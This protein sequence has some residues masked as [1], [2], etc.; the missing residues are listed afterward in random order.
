MPP[1]LGHYGGA[2]NDCQYEPYASVSSVRSCLNHRST[3]FQRVKAG[4]TTNFV[5][6]AHKRPQGASPT[7]GVERGAPR[8]ATCPP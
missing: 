1:A 4:S 3:R 7:P 6:E 5:V 2:P 8:G